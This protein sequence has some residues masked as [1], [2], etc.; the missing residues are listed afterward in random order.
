MAKLLRRQTRGIAALAAMALIVGVLAFTHK[1]VPAAEL[2]LN[3]GG[4]WVTNLSQRLMAHLSYPSRTLDGGVRAASG[5]FDI[6]QNA[7]TV[8]VH[9]RGSQRV[10]N[11]DTAVLTLGQ[12]A[13]V[14]KGIEVVQ[15][16]E[17]AAAADAGTGKVWVM[18]AGEVGSFTP[19]QP[20]TLEK[21]VGARVAVGVDGVV[22][23]IL[24]DGSCKT[25]AAGKVS[26][27]GRIEGIADLATA[28]LSV[29]GDRLVVLDRASSTVRTTKGSTPVT[30]AAGLQ[31][32]QPGP[33]SDK[34]VLAG[35]DAYVYAPLSG[36]TPISVPSG[37]ASGTPVQPVFLGDC[38][39][40]AWTGS[41]QYIRDCGNDA[42]DRHQVVDKVKSATQLVFRVNRDVVV[43]NDLVSGAVLLVND[44][45]RDVE[46]W[47]TV[48]AQTQ[49]KEKQDP[50]SSVE[51]EESTPERRKPTNT[52]PVAVD[53]TFG[54]RAGRSSTLPVLQ[55]DS[56]G[57]GDI[58]TASVKD[59]PAG[60]KV[61]QVRGGEALSIDVP[62]GASGGYAFAYTAEDGRGGTAQ[63]RVSVTVYPDSVNNAPKPL[64]SSAMTLGARAEASYSILG[65]W[66]DPEGDAVYLDHVEAPAGL[67]ARARPD[68]VITVRDTGTGGTGP[69]AL[70]VFVS[71]G[72]AVGE[73]TLTVTVKGDA[74][75]AP[76]ANA[77]HVMA[78]K[79]QEVVV[80]PLANDVSPT[81][82]QL[83]LSSVQAAGAGQKIVPDY[84][85]GTFTFSST[86][87]STS[88]VEYQVTD[89]PSS[90]TGVV[91][92]D[93]AEPE[94]K[95]KPVPTDDLAMLPAGGSVT[96]DA[97]ANDTDPAGGVL[98]IQA[99][100]VPESARGVAVEIVDHGSLRVSA[101]AGLT[102]PVQFTY[103]VANAA[104]SATGRV[105]LLPVGSGATVAPPVAVSDQAV[106]RAGDIVTV[107]VLANDTSPS[108]LSLTL[109]PSVTIE[110]GDATLGDAFVSRDVVRF[111]AKKAGTGRLAYTVRDSAGNY[112]SAEV[113]ITVNAADAPNSPPQPRP[114]VARVLA[115]Q[116]VVIAVPTTG[117]DPDGDSVT[118]VG[119]A[120]AATKGTAVATAD[121]LEYTAADGALGTDT[122]SYEVADRF[123]LRAT[124]TVRVGIAPPNASNQAPVA[125]PDD[126]A[127]RPGRQLSLDPIANDMDP[128]GDTLSLVP[129]SV[130]PTDA[131]TTV[132]A[133]DSGGLVQL[134]A[135]QSQATLRYYY[136]VTDGRGGTAKGVITVKTSADAVLKPP[137]ARDDV[138]T[139]SQLGTSSTVDVDVL[140]NDYDPDGPRGQLTVATDDPGASVVGNKVRVT[141]TDTRQVVLYR[142]TDADGLVGRAAIVVPAA[143]S[144]PPYLDPT[145]LPV[146]VKAGQPL[147]LPLANYVVV[148][149]GH[150][151][152][153][154]Y[155]TKVQTGPGAD[156]SSPIKDAHTLRFASTPEFSGLTSITFE[157]TDGAN[158]DDP[159]GRK[160]T[161]TLPIKVEASAATPHQPVFT[162]SGVSVA[163]GE[164]AVTTDLKQMASDKDPG[165]VDKL[166]FTLGTVTPGFVVHLNGSTLDVSAPADAKSGTTGSAQVTVTDGTTAPVSGSVPLRVTAST[167]PLISV[168]ALSISDARAGQP[169]TI[170]LTSAVTNPFADQGKPVTLVG[171]PTVTAGSGTASASGLSITVTPAAGFHGQMTVG[172]TLADATGDPARQVHG[173]IQAT[174]RDRPDPPTGLVAE[175]HLS[176]TVTL[177]WTAGANNGSPITKF[178][179]KWS[180]GQQDCGAATT[181]TISGLNNNQ[182]YTFTVTA[183]NAVNESLPSS[184]SAS[185]TPDVKPNPPGTPSG[186]FGDKQI[187]LTWAA[188]TTEGS[189][190]TSYS[191]QISPAAGGVTQ[192]DGVTGTSLTWP[193]LTNGTSYTFRVQAHSAAKDPSDWSGSSAAVVPVGLPLAPA[194]PTVAMNPVSTLAPSGT[195]SWQAPD[196]N[197]DTALT[198]ELR[199]SGTSTVLYSGS[200]TSAPVTLAVS[201]SDQQ[202][203][204]HAKNKAGWSA[205]SSPSAAVRAMQLPGSVTNLA[206]TA[207]GQNNQVKISFGAASTN[208]ALPSE[209]AYYWSAN[210]VTNSIGASG[211]TVSDASAFPN[212]QNVTVSVWATSTTNGKTYSG[213]KQSVTVNAYGPPTSPTMSCGVVGTAISCSWS[214]GNANGRPT[215][216]AL[217]GDYSAADGGASGSHDFGDVGYS[218]T[219][220]LCVQAVQQGGAQGNRNCDA[221][222]TPNQPPPPPTV[223]LSRGASAVGQKGCDT[224]SCAYIHVQTANFPGNVTCSANS[225]HGS[226]GWGTWTQG[227]NASRDSPNYY[228]YPGTWV[229]VN[230]GGVTG[231]MTW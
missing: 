116:K 185:V 103:T 151:A 163:A 99:V 29:V 44:N 83:R 40:L 66:I 125:V 132:P 193:G 3:D 107:P 130:T 221:K 84:T 146:T 133:S 192:K 26:D 59:Q 230:C 114:L 147:D 161:L 7:N 148:R 56:D 78:L 160:A 91:R 28:Q 145:K 123:G 98:V 61:A 153:L 22:H 46:N 187:Q 131:T 81:G 60:A 68:G 165:D 30:D 62:A 70:K 49:E 204:V 190:V 110:G 142:I 129:K 220:T 19:D 186:T 27:D 206:V 178:T 88:Y 134:T 173:V 157:V 111:R 154:T 86:T 152:M 216:F 55:N 45:M 150:Q 159:T 175:T 64:R 5:D 222:T 209:M 47:Q 90:A 2:K 141:A 76:I 8:I 158:P 122:F 42:D 202:F 144:A 67:T 179:A 105:T 18:E 228:G 117:T 223:S 121:T 231:S 4:V 211:G 180:G 140:A 24:P 20:P 1:G 79:N 31:L 137:V 225:Q 12:G 58:L 172:F 97:L 128:D 39:Y 215:Q 196:G 34:A 200:A 164:P 54:V 100:D 214:G 136:G 13:P 197:G 156:T 229:S 188:S 210:G 102:G 184:P 33:V 10:Q 126:I 139:A 155:S 38:A 96:V 124:G 120:G 15:G 203:E 135:P 57:D 167:R 218:A 212:G 227:P 127:T 205:W 119:V 169:S 51:T 36:G 183:T 41:G 48:Q 63:A 199:K 195:V 82:A 87:A 14:S 207:T 198:Y 77:D 69:K 71:D 92:I 80:K 138:V 73:G 194:A 53:D 189:P 226:A 108:G 118:L 191:V 17:V 50:Q 65:D 171:Q 52:A 104:G 177:S 170:D 21:A 217:S 95:G 181:C 176:R 201:T 37:A 109:D 213:P 106:V 25:V 168:S 75:I 113:V 162:P 16:G 72:R 93:V 85:S 11:V 101:P 182:A 6:S 32:Q 112:D 94:V 166:R 208:G 23:V 224:A 35:K 143:D 89:G 149:S 9:D 43:L 74:S 174:V 219:R 115:G